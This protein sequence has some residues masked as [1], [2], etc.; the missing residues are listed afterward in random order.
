MNNGGKIFYK[1]MRKHK[2]SHIWGYSGGA[3]MPIFD[4]LYKSK[5]IKTIISAHEQFCGHSA[6]G[7]AKSSRYKGKH[8][9]PKTGVAVV[10]SGPGLTNI[11]TPLLDA[12]TDGTPLIVFSGQVPI[13]A[14]GSNAF[15]EAPSIEMTKS[16][17]KWNY[18]VED[19]NEFES[20][21]DE[22]F[23]V[24]NNGKKG[25]VHIDIPKCV[26][27]QKLTNP[28]TIKSNQIKHQYV[29]TYNQSHNTLPFYDLGK[30]I[31][32][33]KKPILYI[34]QGCHNASKELREFAIKANIPV[35]S[36]IHGCGVFDETHPLSLRWCGMHGSAAANYALQEADLILA[37][38][39]RFDD[40][41]TGNVTNYAPKAFEAYKNGTGGIVHVNIC[42]D[43]FGFAVKS[44]YNYHTDC[45]Y[46][47][48]TM[49]HFVKHMGRKEW[50]QYLYKNKDRHPFELKKSNQQLHIEHII[51]EIDNFTTNSP[52]KTIITTGVGNHQ[53]QTYQFIKSRYPKNVISSGSLGVMGTGLPYAIGA[54][55]ANPTYL[56]I[57]IDGDS[58]FNMS[59]SD[60]KT[61]REHKIPVK[62]AIMNNQRQMMVNVWERL[63]Y[64]ERYTATINTHNPNYVQLANSFGIDAMYCDN[65]N[66]LKYTIKQF[67]THKG[68]IL[69]EFDI[70]P[71]ICLPLVGPGNALD[72]MLLPNESVSPTFMGIP[73]S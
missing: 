54:Q 65:P 12:N 60:L 56:V 29:N 10:T 26:S 3:I 16:I 34:G 13:A 45:K 44:H 36:T 57:D 22:A 15:Q 9:G 59:L 19:I 47:L 20:V 70:V 63:F 72:D 30:L 24:A 8:Y 25:S 64:G 55:M 53:M 42:E 33:S 38:G 61:I 69:C 7:F 41:T 50:Q 52:K 67:L 51:S 43:E 27:Y 17:T 21:I 14:K 58:S 71:D 66:N 48:E 37:V 39:S 35:T 32:K 2:V 5:A 73:P 49:R 18:S 11:I 4:S 6:T 68:P 40:R 31:N 46:F 62:I 23:K 1:T 28:K